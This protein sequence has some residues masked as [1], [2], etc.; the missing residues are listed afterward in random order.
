MKQ[1]KRQGAILELAK[2]AQEGVAQKCLL[3][4][5]EL[6]NEED[7]RRFKQ[8]QMDEKLASLPPEG[9]RP[10]ACPRCGKNARVRAKE[11]PR[12][13]SSL[14]GTHTIK[15]NHHFC[16]GCKEGLFPRDEFLGLPKEG[17]ASIELERR[18]ADFL[19]NDVFEEAEARW[20]FHYPHLKASSNQ[21]RQ[22]GKRLGLK[23]EEANAELLQ[24]ALLPPTPQRPST[25]YVMNDS[26]MV[27]LRGEWRAVK[28]GTLF[29]EENHVSSRDEKRGIVSTAR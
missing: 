7:G 11:V 17:E 19:V 27:P 2:A 6:Q 14:S 9:T 1:T 3:S 28:V 16:E 12:T 8:S 23:A 26:G 18:M 21:F 20:N 4:Q 22:I 15:R 10:K 24:S 25:L 5:M 29:R 13:F